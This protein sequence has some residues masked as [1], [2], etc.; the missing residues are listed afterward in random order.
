MDPSIIECSDQLVLRPAITTVDN[1]PILAKT[2]AIATAQTMAPIVEIILRDDRGR[3][4]NFE[5]CGFTSVSSSS[6]GGSSATP[7]GKVYIKGREALDVSNGIPLI[8]IEGYFTDAAAGVIRAKVPATATQLHQIIDVNCGVVSAA[9]EMI[10]MTNMYLLVDK[11]QFGSVVA[12]NGKPAGLPSLAQI[13]T[14]LRDNA[15]EDNPLLNTFEFDVSEIVQCMLK[16]VELW[17]TTQPR[18]RKVYNTN[19]FLNPSVLI[20]GVMGELYMIAAKHYR[21]NS[22]AYSAGGLSVDDKNKAQEYEVIGD[23]MIQEYGKWCKMTKVELNKEAWDGSFGS[24]YDGFGR[25]R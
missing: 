15:P 11:S 22:L 10:H 24:T 1:R 21:R 23:R 7:Q 4:I 17:N 3:P 16:C 25:Y 5:Q 19:N 14:F 6:I 9:G 13:R 18:V 20:N 8:D 2:P 12:N